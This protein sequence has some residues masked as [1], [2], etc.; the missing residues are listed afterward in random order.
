MRKT[1][2]QCLRHLGEYV[3]SVSSLMVHSQPNRES[4]ERSENL[5]HFRIGFFSGFRLQHQFCYT[6]RQYLY[7]FGKVRVFSIQSRYYMHILASCPDKISRLTRE[8]FFSKSE[9]TAP[10][11][12]TGFNVNIS[13][14]Y[15]HYAE[16]IYHISYIM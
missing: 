12:A 8:R 10:R 14:W 13:A 9:N 16:I 7:S 5:G 11:V 3:A 6:H 2:S 15:W 1:T 4:L